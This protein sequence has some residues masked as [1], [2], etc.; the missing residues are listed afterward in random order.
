MRSI[1]RRSS[2][3][4]GVSDWDGFTMTRFAAFLAHRPVAGAAL[5]GGRTG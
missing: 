3:S 4:D 2:P 1:S 5:I